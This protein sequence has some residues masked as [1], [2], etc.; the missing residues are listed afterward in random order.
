[1]VRTQIYLTQEEQ[2]AI[3]SLSKTTGKKQSSLIR[4]AI[5]TYITKNQK[6]ERKKGLDRIAGIWK[7]RTDLPDL[8]ELRKGWNRGYY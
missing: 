8:R 2:K 4:E 1:M 7:N 5:D 3:R 6:I